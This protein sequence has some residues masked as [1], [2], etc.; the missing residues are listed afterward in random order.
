MTA[1]IPTE[2]P[3]AEV[4]QGVKFYYGYCEKNVDV[5]VVV[6]SGSCNNTAPTI[7][8]SAGYWKP[9]V[10]PS[11]PMQKLKDDSVKQPKDSFPF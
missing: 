7:P 4:I 11:L 8:F 1:P 10:K 3:L 6:H 5:P 2:K 9:H